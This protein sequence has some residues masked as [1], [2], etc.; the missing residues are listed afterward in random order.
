MNVPDN[1]L[2]ERIVIDCMASDRAPTISELF[3]VAERIW[4]EGAVGRSAYSWSRLDA[5]D[6]EKLMAL[7]AAKV[8]LLGSP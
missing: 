2:F 3:G 1:P 5:T 7:R 4:K 8:A 6:P